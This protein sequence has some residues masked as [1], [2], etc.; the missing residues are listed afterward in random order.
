MAHAFSWQEAPKHPLRRDYLIGE[1][2]INPP[3]VSI[4]EGHDAIDLDLHCRVQDQRV[5]SCPA[6]DTRRS[7][8]GDNVGIFRIR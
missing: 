3:K 5:V 1:H 8:M 4:V 6:Q 7:E 2:R